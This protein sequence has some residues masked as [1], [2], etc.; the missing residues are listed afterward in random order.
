M[1][2]VPK[3]KITFANIDVIEKSLNWILQLSALLSIL[4]LLIELFPTSLKY[5][6]IITL[7]H[8]LNSLI[9][10]MSVSYTITIVIRNYIFYNAETER[11]R[12]YIDNSLGTNLQEFKSVNYFSND[13]VTIGIRKLGINCYE[14]SYF[15]FN[16]AMKM[17]SSRLKWSFLLFLVYMFI[18]TQADKCIVVS[19]LQIA[20]PAA[21]IIETII[22]WHFIQNIRN[23]NENFK[24]LFSNSISYSNIGVIIHNVLLYEKTISHFT[25]KLD[26]DIFNKLNSQLSQEW[27]SIKGNYRLG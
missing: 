22:L 25:I 21:Y 15:T 6:N 17:F 20:L 8:F 16:I 27:E 5:I 2:S 26:S 1:S 18:F 3:F 9:V 11:Y 7:K 23:V 13:E 10:V 14:N 12:D 24:L 19:Y 4:Y